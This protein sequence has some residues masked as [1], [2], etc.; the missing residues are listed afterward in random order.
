[1]KNLLTV[2]LTAIIMNFPLLVF[3][4]SFIFCPDIQTEERKGFDK[5]KISIVMDDSRAYEKKKKEQCTKD[6]I[7]EEFVN[8]IKRTYPNMQITV[9][10]SKMFYENP[11]KGNITIKVKFKQYDATFY[12]GRYISNTKY[13]VKIFDNRNEENIIEQVITGE[14]KQFNALGSKSGKIASNKSFKEAFDN[15]ILMVEKLK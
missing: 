9:L 10:D 3:C 7:F 8:C 12:T 11:I 4:Q 13:E 2:L 6:Q 5:V 1:M 15:F 14:A